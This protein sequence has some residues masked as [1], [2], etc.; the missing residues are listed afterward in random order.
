[1]SIHTFHGGKVP[2]SGGRLIS[3]PQSGGRLISSTFGQ[4]KVFLPQAQVGYGIGGVLKPLARTV[5]TAAKGQLKKLPKYLG[6]LA[7]RHGKKAAKQVFAAAVSGQLKK[8]Q[9]KKTLKRIVASN[10][11]KAQQN[12]KKDIKK[13]VLKSV[14]QPKSKAKKQSVKR[15]ALFLP[16]RRKPIKKRRKDI[17]DK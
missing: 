11:Q 14:R 8:G 9:R 15:K 1:M 12:I 2:Q 3:I 16:Y 5:Y 4:P 13:A 10:V 7:K 17:F 6:K